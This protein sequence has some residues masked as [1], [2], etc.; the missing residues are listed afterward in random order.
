MKK[1]CNQ[2]VLYLSYKHN[3]NNKYINN[4]KGLQVFHIIR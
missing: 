1:K 2:N 4:N 3:N